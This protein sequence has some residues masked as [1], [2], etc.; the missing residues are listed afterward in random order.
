MITE[1]HLASSPHLP[2]HDDIPALY[3]ELSRDDSIVQLPSQFQ[4]QEDKDSQDKVEEDKAEESATGNIEEFESQQSSES[5]LKKEKMEKKMEMEKREKMKVAKNKRFDPMLGTPTE[6][7]GSPLKKR[8]LRYLGFT[9]LFVM[10]CT[11][12]F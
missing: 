12:I 3:S 7:T 1:N 8:P 9:L 4:G 2:R 11:E 5:L 10:H 6:R